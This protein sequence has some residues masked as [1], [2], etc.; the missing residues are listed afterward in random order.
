MGGVVLVEA[1]N[2]QLYSFWLTHREDPL[3][4]R[5]LHSAEMLNGWWGPVIVLNGG[6]LDPH[7]RSL[8]AHP[9]RAGNVTRME[10]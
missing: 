3:I 8:V 2:F 1:P 6:S 10:V 4:Y 9:S 7:I 5:Y